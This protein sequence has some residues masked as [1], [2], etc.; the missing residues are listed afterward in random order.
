MVLV[1]YSLIRL[2]LLLCYRCDLAP[3]E[4]VVMLVVTIH[5]LGSCYNLQNR[6]RFCGC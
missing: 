2:L 6:N 1:I 5:N 3:T 4:V